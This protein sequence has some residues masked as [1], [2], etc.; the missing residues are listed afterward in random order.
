MTAFRRSFP[1]ACLLLMRREMH[2]T[3]SPSPFL[4]GPRSWKENRY[5]SIFQLRVTVFPLFLSPIFYLHYS[6]D[7]RRFKRGYTSCCT[8]CKG[9][10]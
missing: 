8:K 7:L 10:P 9:S 2:H 4:F 3:S 6:S 1:H 5:R